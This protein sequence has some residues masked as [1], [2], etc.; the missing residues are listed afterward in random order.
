MPFSPLISAVDD[1]WP[2]GIDM[3]A[4]ALTGAIMIGLPALGWAILVIDVRRY[5]RAL[6]ARALVV[7]KYFTPRNSPF[8]LLRDRPPCLQALGLTMPCTEDEVLAAYRTK[9]KDLHPDRGGEMQ[10]FLQLQKHFE[11][12]LYLVR[13]QALQSDAT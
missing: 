1:G 11:Q 4:L 9:V 13:Q 6:R 7:V 3:F 10:R 5:L 8:W 12:A 2:D